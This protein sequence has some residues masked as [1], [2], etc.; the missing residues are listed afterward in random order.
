M[1]LTEPVVDDASHVDVAADRRADPVVLSDN[2]EPDVVTVKRHV[3]ILVSTSVRP[4]LCQRRQL[5]VPF[6]QSYI[7]FTRKK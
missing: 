2:V 5:R 7:A 3:A 1:N 4:L 6:L